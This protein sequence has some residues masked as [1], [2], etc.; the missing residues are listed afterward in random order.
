[1]I[2]WALSRYYP[3]AES[4]L[5]IGCGTGFV[6]SAVG[7]Q[8][9]SMQ[10]SGTDIFP[11]GLLFA[12]NRIRRAELIQMDA[13]SMPFREE[14]D[15][16][17][18]FDVIEHIKED[19]QVLSQIHRALRPG[20]V[21]LLT[22]PQHP[23]MWSTMDDHAG[24]VRRYRSGELRSKVRSAGFEVLRM[25]SFV[26]MLL[27]AMF[28]ARWRMRSRN[29]PYSLTDEFKIHPVMNRLF[30]RM[31][32]VERLLIRWGVNWPAGGSLLLAARKA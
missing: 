28:Y 8:Y 9:P 3:L 27:P 26:S 25:T 4:F 21:V 17:G 1:M 10:L 6:L 12:R 24:H 18:A 31:L 20:G 32:D 7:D 29:R 5:E 13:R 11:A 2:L 22:V 30:E 19:E 16:I 23:R 14:F 15:I